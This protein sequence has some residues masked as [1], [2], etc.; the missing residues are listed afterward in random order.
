[1]AKGK[2]EDSQLNRRNSLGREGYIHVTDN[3]FVIVTG[4]VCWSMTYLASVKNSKLISKE[5]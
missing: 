2:Q 1:M 5:K 3:A 4:G